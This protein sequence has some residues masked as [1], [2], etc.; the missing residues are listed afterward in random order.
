MG[1][2]RIPFSIQGMRMDK[3]IVRRGGRE[4]GIWHIRQASDD[5]KEEDSSCLKTHGCKKKRRKR[6]YTR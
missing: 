5:D 1:G 6:V 2:A 4:N 3:E